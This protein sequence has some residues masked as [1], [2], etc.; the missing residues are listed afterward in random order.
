M[1]KNNIAVD[2]INFGEQ[3]ENHLMKI[4]LFHENVDKDNNSSLIN[5]KPGLS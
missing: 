1:K 5:L 4:K 2:I 3:N